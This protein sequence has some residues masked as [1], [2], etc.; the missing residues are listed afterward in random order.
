MAAPYAKLALFELSYGINSAYLSANKYIWVETNKGK[1]WSDLTELE[2]IK[3]D[4]EYK[5]YRENHKALVLH[6]AFKLFEPVN[7]IISDT[8]RKEKLDKFNTE[9]PEIISLVKTKNKIL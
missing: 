3:Y 9:T 1:K 5:Q 2:K 6:E 7:K 4:K 8:I